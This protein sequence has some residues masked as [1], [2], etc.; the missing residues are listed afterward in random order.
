MNPATSTL[1]LANLAC[2]GALPFVF[3]RRD[4]R[5]HAKWWLTAAPFFLC[6]AFLVAAATRLVKPAGY[7]TA[8]GQILAGLAVPLCVGSIALIFLTMGVHRVP[9]A[10]W[11]Q[12]DDA[13]RH[14]VTYG[15]YRRVRH[16]FYA[17]FLLALVGAAVYAPHPLS[18]ALVLYGYL[19][20]NHA[21][22]RE[23]SRL[24]GSQL[25]P[26]YERYMRR[27]GRFLPAVGREAR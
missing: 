20:L 18:L 12:D 10:L 11:H 7:G 1:C 13:P 25:G 14:I 17:A 9:L 19:A 5:L 27:T 3:F 26:E 21:A 6:A 8:T 2:I 24:R 22:A 16:P 15:P 23:E 4:G